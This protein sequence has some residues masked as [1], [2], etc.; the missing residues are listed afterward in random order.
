LEPKGYGSPQDIIAF[1]RQSRDG[2][3]WGVAQLTGQEDAYFAIEEVWHDVRSVY[4]PYL[5]AQPQNAW[6][7][8]AYAYYASLGQHWEE[9]QRQFSKLGD[10]AVPQQFG[11]QEAMAKFRQQAQQNGGSS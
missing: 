3:N 9:A 2:R 10:T 4:E 8:S 7:R 6:A 5:A 1:G 11:G